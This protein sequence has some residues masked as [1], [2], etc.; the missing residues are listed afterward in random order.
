MKTAKSNTRQTTGT[1]TVEVVAIAAERVSLQNQLRDLF[2]EN[3]LV[4][5]LAKRLQQ[6][7]FG[8]CGTCAPAPT[9]KNLEQWISA[10]TKT[11]Q[12]AHTLLATI[13]QRIEA[14]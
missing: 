10:A 6:K 13:N 4:L 7:L 12:E 11:A 9:P 3:D 2:A 5:S 1:A 8:E 14:D